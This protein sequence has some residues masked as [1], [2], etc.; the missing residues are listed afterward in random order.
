M[1][2]GTN[3]QYKLLLCIGCM[4]GGYMWACLYLPRAFLESSCIWTFLLYPFVP[5]TMSMYFCTN[6]K[7]WKLA[8]ERK[9]LLRNRVRWGALLGWAMDKVLALLH[10]GGVLLHFKPSPKDALLC[11]GGIPP[12]PSQY[13]LPDSFRGGTL[14][15]PGMRQTPLQFGLARERKEEECEEEGGWP[16]NVSHPAS[17]STDTFPLSS[18]LQKTILLT[19]VSHRRICLFNYGEKSISTTL[20]HQKLY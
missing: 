5:C 19:G 8:R 4:W 13:P 1:R 12:R 16:P 9:V 7:K 15:E 6:I 17:C 20:V 14:E 10:C 18:P 2:H 11:H 3:E